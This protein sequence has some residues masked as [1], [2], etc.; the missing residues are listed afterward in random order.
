MH[1]MELD[2]YWRFESRREK[3]LTSIS[4]FLEQQKRLQVF[5]MNSGQVN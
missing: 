1:Y 4:N 2:R 3:L 5:V